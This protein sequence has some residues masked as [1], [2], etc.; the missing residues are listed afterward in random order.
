MWLFFLIRRGAGGQGHKRKRDSARM[1]AYSRMMATSN[2]L[3]V[4]RD[5]CM[6]GQGAP[7]PAL[8]WLITYNRGPPLLTPFLDLPDFARLSLLSTAFR[9]IIS[10]CSGKIGEKALHEARTC[11]PVEQWLLDP[12]ITN[13][14]AL[15]VV[16]LLRGQRKCY[17]CDQA[18][19][20][21]P[22]QPSR[23]TIIYCSRRE[24]SLCPRCAALRGQRESVAEYIE[25]K[26]VVLV[27]KSGGTASLD[28]ARG[29]AAASYK[30]QSK[31]AA[32]LV[33]AVSPP[34]TTFRQFLVQR[35]PLVSVI[36]N[37]V[38]LA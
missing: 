34:G 35:C 27:N 16:A 18:L 38:S 17:C 8:D 15:P 24:A 37:Q 23:M 28:S 4:S 2:K 32:Q 20:L 14:S 25:G 19:F 21:P 9:D 29:V 36:G 7:R 11:G 13:D 12:A 30:G 6:R 26:V 10:Q 3:R 1:A 33:Q 31:T 22:H 5:L